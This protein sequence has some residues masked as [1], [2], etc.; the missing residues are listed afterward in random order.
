MRKKHTVFLQSK[1]FLILSFL[2]LLCFFIFRNQFIYLYKYFSLRLFY[3]NLTSLQTKADWNSIYNLFTDEYKNSIPREKFIITQN[4]FKKPISQQYIVHSYSILN[5]KGIVD[6]T[7][8]SCY[9]AGCN[10]SDR[11]EFRTRFLYLFENG[12]WRIPL[13]G[14][15]KSFCFKDKPYK[16]SPEFERALSIIFQRYSNNVSDKDYL[17]SFNAIK[18]C[19]SIEYSND[20][21]NA[22]GFFIFDSNLVKQDYLPIFVNNKYKNMDDVS[23][24][25]L[26]SHELAHLYQ[27]MRVSEGQDAQSCVANEAEAFY[28]QFALS[29][30]LNPG[31]RLN[32][33]NLIDQYYYG[34]N[35]N[36]QLEITKH[37]H[38]LSIEAQNICGTSSECWTSTFYQKLEKMVKE[39]PFY[40]E[41][42]S[43]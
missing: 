19:L 9:S 5:N 7:L 37:L 39:N 35:P 3:N 2:A 43:K 8:I 16:L 21:S 33:A 36:P 1:T 11:N 15:F 10:G 23:T 31:E 17:D 13:S 14:P 22:E 6:R 28:N 25:I 27:F 29:V 38:E 40:Q 4:Q 41:Q 20:I 12:S 26:L 32:L 30:R 34:V 42:C 24:A 18:N